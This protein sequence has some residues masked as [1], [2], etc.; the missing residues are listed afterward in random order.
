MDDGA[1]DGDLDLQG[2][3]PYTARIY[4]CYLGGKAL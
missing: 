3:R 2:D 4:D 1:T